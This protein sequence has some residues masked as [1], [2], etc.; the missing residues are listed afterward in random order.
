MSGRHRVDAPKPLPYVLAATDSR[1]RSVAEELAAAYPGWW[2]V[3]GSYWRC[4]SAFA[5]FTVEPLVLHGVDAGV[6]VTRM[7]EVEMAIRTPPV[8]RE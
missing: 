4:W 8:H 2:V 7:R 5:L 1:E 6:L 3:W